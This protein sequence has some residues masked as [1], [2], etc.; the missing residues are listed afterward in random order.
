MQALVFYGPGNIALEEKPRP[1]VKQPTDA[2]VRI[3]K[4]TI[5][6]TDLHILKEDVPT[7]TE[8]RILGH[9]GVGIVEEVGNSVA[10]FRPGDRVLISCITSCGNRLLTFANPL[11]PPV[12]VLPMS[13]FMEKA[14]SCIWKPFGR[15]TLH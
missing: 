14:W 13:A 15:T 7:V 10:N 5:C 2:I 8:G 11:S 4:T 1:A 12:V 9:E 6:G 3:T